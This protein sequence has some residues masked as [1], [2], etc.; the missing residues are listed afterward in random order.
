[1]NLDGYYKAHTTLALLDASGIT[2]RVL[3]RGVDALDLLHRLSTND[4]RPLFNSP[5]KGAQTILTTEKAR[6]ID[7]LTVIATANGALLVT[8]KDHEQSVISWLDKFTIMEDAKFTAVS[9]DISHFM[10]F[11]PRALE[12][13]TSATSVDLISLQ[14]F[15]SVELQ[16]ASIPI[17]L[18]KTARI[19][20]SGFSIYCDSTDHDALLAIMTEQLSEFGGAI[21]DEDTYETVRIEAGI[22]KAPNELNDKHNPLETALVQAVS[23]TKGCYTG[24][25]VIARLDTY[26]KVQRHLMGVRCRAEVSSSLPIVCYGADGTTIGE[27]TSLT[28]SPILGVSIGIAFIKTA[29]ANPNSLITVGDE[30]LPAT[31][32]NL[33]F[34]IES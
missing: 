30:H 24:Q 14:Q 7:L 26:D 20:E 16:L 11:G 2:G 29:F 33:P 23:F 10:V 21:I 27:I 4:L 8:S 6:I 1:M 12:F 22:S 31:L 15:D 19:I 3:A 13:L 18:Q 32:I 25:E 28:I 17:R 34:E 5:G 9:N